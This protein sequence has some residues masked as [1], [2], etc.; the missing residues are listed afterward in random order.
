MCHYEHN[1]P[2]HRDPTRL[3]ARF[4]AVRSDFGRLLFS[5]LPQDTA[6]EWVANGEAYVE[7]PDAIRLYDRTHTLEECTPFHAREASQRA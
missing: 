2:E 1:S 7:A 4:I 3:T 6:Q 5:M